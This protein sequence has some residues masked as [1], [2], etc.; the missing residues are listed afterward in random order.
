M[1][2]TN[3][4]SQLRWIEGPPKEV[5]HI[6][7]TQVDFQKKLAIVFERILE[8]QGYEWSALVEIHGIGDI[9]ITEHE[10]LSSVL[11]FS[12]AYPL[13]F[14]YACDELK[15][16]FEIPASQVLFEGDTRFDCPPY[17]R[18]TLTKFLEDFVNSKKP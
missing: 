13:D 9:L 4:V 14:R 10:L 7:A 12:V 5:L 6:H 2:M 3:S 18:S 1:Q 15:R 17:N 11:I 16:F 8:G